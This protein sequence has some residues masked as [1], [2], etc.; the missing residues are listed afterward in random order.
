MPDKHKAVGR[1]GAKRPPNN[2]PA[3]VGTTVSEGRRRRAPAGRLPPEY[4][5]GA[6]ACEVDDTFEPHV[7]GIDYGMLDQNV[8]YAIRRAQIAIY[9][10]L[11]RALAPWGMSPQRYS[12]M[13]LIA[14]NEGLTQSRLASLLGIAGSGAVMV[15]RSL[16]SMGYVD[17]APSLT[18]ARAYSLKLTSAGRSAL[19]NIDSA[20][21]EH[22]ARVTAALSTKDRKSL[23]EL[24][25]RL[26]V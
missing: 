25:A 8:G 1:G 22:E 14:R 12:A 19:K 6:T 17:H 4:S 11:Y 20:V 15:I 18:D 16:K 9:V 2:R 5:P 7:S 23:I 3:M 13:T 21:I 26:H 24:L 10:D